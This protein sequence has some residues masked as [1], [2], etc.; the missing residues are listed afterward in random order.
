M[1]KFIG[2]TVVVTG[3][4]SG[5]G[6]TTSEYFARRGATIVVTDIDLSSANETLNK[7]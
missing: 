7:I 5:L 2:K 4:G 1:D 6:K 3:A